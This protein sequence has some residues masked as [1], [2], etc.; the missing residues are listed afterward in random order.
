MDTAAPTL[1][2]APTEKLM[3]EIVEPQLKRLALWADPRV[4]A[5]L[6]QP[7]GGILSDVGSS[8]RDLAGLA[9]EAL[10]LKL[11]RILDMDYAGTRLRGAQTGGA[12]VGL[13]FQS[14][15][16]VLN[17]WQIQCK[18]SAR[19]SIDDVAKEVGL[20][21]LLKGNVIVIVTTGT[22]DARA[23]RYAN[24]VMA[25]SSLA[26]VLIDGRDLKTIARSP[27]RIVG[28]FEREARHAL[29]LKKLDEVAEQ[30]SRRPAPSLLDGAPES[31]RT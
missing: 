16:L 7:L 29:E 19:M 15:R 11:M 13:I 14:N 30:N 9:L 20:T 25:D 5:L 10:V 17:R 1:R 3:A 4:V 6:R 21:H 22:V 12:E 26:V 31:D 18:N 27:T 24:R 23:R 2:V 8:D 28:I